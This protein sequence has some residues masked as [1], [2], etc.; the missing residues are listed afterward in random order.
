ML[1]TVSEK[2]AMQKPE[3]QPPRFWQW[4][5]LVL[6]VAGLIGAAIFAKSS[7]GVDW[8]DGFHAFPE[9]IE[10]MGWWG[11]A[12][13]IALMIVHCFVPFP[14]EFVAIAAGSAFGTFYGTLYTWTGAMLGAMLSFA[15]TRIFGQPFVA[16]ALP[17]RQKAAL[18]KWTEDQGAVTLLISRFIPVIAFNLINYAAG[19]TKVSWW[20]FF[21]TT[22]IGILPLTALMVYMGAQMTYLS[23]EWLVG[24]SVVCI[25]LMAAL[26]WYKRKKMG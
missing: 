26:H 4:G 17:E 15:L 22:G 13:I 23:W 18:D 25:A 14:A 11:P 5:V 16:W 7:T 12:G 9:M 3:R 20:T 21:W 2:G 1:S 6:F 10:E 24:V 8:I 19:L